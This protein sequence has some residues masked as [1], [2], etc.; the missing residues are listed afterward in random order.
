[1]KNTLKNIALGATLVGAL[2]SA[3]C[4][5][6]QDNKDSRLPEVRN[7][8]TLILHPDY[9]RGSSSLGYTL[10]TDMDYDGSWD[11]AERVH[12]GFTTGDGSRKLIYKKGYGPAQSVDIPV[13]FAE[14]SYFK[15]FE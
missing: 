4:E 7:N 9:L 10:L 6:E 15:A 12:V 11:V 2:F 13:E 14:P 8:Q 5:K 3:G 1:M